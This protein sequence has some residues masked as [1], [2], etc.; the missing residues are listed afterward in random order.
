MDEEEKVVF[1]NDDVLLVEWDILQYKYFSG[2][3]A[4]VSCILFY[5]RFGMISHIMTIQRLRY[6][7]SCEQ[8]MESDVITLDQCLEFLTTPER[9]GQDNSWYFEP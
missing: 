6:H 7:S 5:A 8:R 3:N 1:N 4:S 9:L 2:E